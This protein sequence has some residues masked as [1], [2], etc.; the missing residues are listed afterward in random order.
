[1][2][3]LTDR[4]NLLEVVEL[5]IDAMRRSDP[6]YVRTHGCQQCTGE[7]WDTAI[8]AGE[9]VLEAELSRD[10][11]KRE[12]EMNQEAADASAG[13]AARLAEEE[14]AHRVTAGIFASTLVRADA[15]EARIKPLEETVAAQYAH[16]V[17][18]EVRLQKVM[19]RC[20]DLL[21]EDQFNELDALARLTDSAI[22]VHSSVVQP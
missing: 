20:A 12:A 11:W 10:S 6:D 14:S 3:D 1:M 16:N 5:L 21:D 15:A 4:A 17:L 19:A 9:D 22:P 7:D 8:Q 2:I 18:L 13:Y